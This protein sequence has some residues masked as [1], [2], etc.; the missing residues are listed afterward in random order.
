MALFLSISNGIMLSGWNSLVSLLVMRAGEPQ[1]VQTVEEVFLSVTICAPHELQTISTLPWSSL[2]RTSSIPYSSSGFVIPI[3]HFISIVF[4]SKTRPQL[5]HAKPS[6]LGLKI[7]LAPHEGHFFAFE[8]I[9][10]IGAS[11]TVSVFGVFAQGD[12]EA[13]GAAG[14]SLFTLGSKKTL[15]RFFF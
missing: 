9:T 5:V 6:A 14:A 10:L 7:R 1:K 12:V 15:S 8:E 11:S 2:D 3:D 13:Q 4:G